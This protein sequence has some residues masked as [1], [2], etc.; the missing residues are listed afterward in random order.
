M[1]KILNRIEKELKHKLEYLM[2]YNDVKFP[3]FLPVLNNRVENYKDKTST[4]YR[5]IHKSEYQKVLR[6]SLS[7]AEVEKMLGVLGY[8]II[9]KKGDTVIE[10]VKF[11]LGYI[12]VKYTELMAVCELL[13][14]DIEWV[15]N[16]D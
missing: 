5:N 9:F 12:K 2:T 10:P 13:G 16:E 3:V 8:K 14:I 7:V 1:A 6:A 11:E 4:A 15:K